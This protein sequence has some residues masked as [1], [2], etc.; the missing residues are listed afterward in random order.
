MSPLRAKFRAELR[1]P[2]GNVEEKL[3]FDLRS[4]VLRDAGIE[5][6]GTMK[7]PVL[8]EWSLI[9]TLPDETRFFAHVVVVACE[10]VAVSRWHLALYFLQVEEIDTEIRWLSA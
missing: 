1:P 4:L 6:E 3:A 5:F 2:A 9:L 8:T 10:P 7:L